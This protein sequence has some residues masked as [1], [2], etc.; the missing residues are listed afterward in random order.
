MGDNRF[1][2]AGLLFPETPGSVIGCFGRFIND[3]Y[4]FIGEERFT[5][6]PHQQA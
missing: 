5:H 2:N 4:F 1:K 3:Q 6:H